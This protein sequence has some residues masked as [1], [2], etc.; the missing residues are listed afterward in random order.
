MDNTNNEIEDNNQFRS[1]ADKNKTA[2]KNMTKKEKLKHFWFY[3]KLHTFGVIFVLLLIAFTLQQCATRV[4]PDISVIVMT[5]KNV[6]PTDEQQKIID[7]FSSI[8]KDVN[9]DG[10][11]S[12]EVQFLYMDDSEAGQAMIVKLVA[13]ISSSNAILYISD[14]TEFDRYKDES[15]FDEITNYIPNAKGITEYKL[16]IEDTTLASGSYGKYMSGL[17]VTVRKYKGTG[18]DNKA[19]LPYYNNSIQVLEKLVLQ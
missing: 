3:Y 8:T 2:V 19:N 7:Y 16:P 11:K 6:V 17:S 1:Q 13:S 9:G 14:D 5:A 12:A 4:D 15:L 18:I 10:K